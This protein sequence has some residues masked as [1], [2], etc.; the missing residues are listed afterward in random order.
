MELLGIDT[1]VAEK[2]AKTLSRNRSEF[3]KIDVYDNRFYPSSN[4]SVENVLR[5]FLVMVAMD[6][7]LSR[8]GKAYSACLDDGC[9]KGADLLYKL[10]KKKFDESPDF[11]SPEKLS[12]VRVEE[13]EKWLS[14]GET[15]PVDLELR[16]YLLKDLGLKLLKIYDGSVLSI[17]NSAENRLHGD[18]VRPGLTDLL[19]VFTAYQDPVE[20]KTMLLGKFLSLRDIFKPID[21]PYIPVDNHL[22]R[23]ALRTGL[24]VLSGRLWNKIVNS[25]EVLPEE[26]IMIRLIVREAY[27]YLSEK[28]GVNVWEL[29]DHFWNHGRKMCLRDERPLCEKCWFKGIC[30]ARRN[31]AFMVIEHV[32]FNTWFY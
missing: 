12:K 29:D 6:H 9:Y 11:F 14:V 28:S 4:E 30:R 20:K 21:K 10:G 22:T 18:G 1:S 13:V 16:T 27:G 17:V 8:P 32:F 7:R 5:Y 24:V 19:K 2:M 3:Q 31:S 25:T 15:R 26:D 23:I